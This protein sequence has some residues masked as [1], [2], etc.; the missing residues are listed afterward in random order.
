MMIKTIKTPTFLASRLS[1]L[2]IKTTFSNSVASLFN[3]EEDKPVV[4][5][6]ISVYGSDSMSPYC[7]LSTWR[8]IAHCRVH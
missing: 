7:V 5:T 6:I 8:K 2:R 4:G 3:D 1:P